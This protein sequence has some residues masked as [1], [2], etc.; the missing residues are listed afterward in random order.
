MRSMGV[1]TRDNV[2]TPGGRAA[3]VFLLMVVG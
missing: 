1:S 2:G 3:I